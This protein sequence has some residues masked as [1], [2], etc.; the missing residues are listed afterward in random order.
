MKQIDYCLFEAPLGT[1]GIAWSERENS[2]APPAV[3]FLQ[4]PEATTGRTE[5]RIQQQSGAGNASVPPPRIAEVIERVRKHL[6]GEVQDF[7][8]VLLDLDGSPPFARRVYQA[9]RKIP[10][11]QT[12][13]YGELARAAGGPAAARAV[14]QALRK[15]PIALIIPCHR[16]LAAGG[17]LGGFSAHGGRATKTRMLAIEGVTFERL[18]ATA[19]VAR[20]KPSIFCAAPSS[21]RP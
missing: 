14:G 1:F 13:T 9:A 10:V 18:S 19:P 5:S 4:L 20:P 12:M 7:Q 11:G 2:S 21:R 8:D 17:S 3:A 15:N 16:V 6:E